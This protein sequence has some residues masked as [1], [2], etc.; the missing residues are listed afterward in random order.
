M[1]AWL[2]DELTGLKGLRLADVPAP[3]P[4]AGG[5]QE[6]ILFELLLKFGFPLT[7]QIEALTL[8]G[9]TVFSIADGTMLVCL[10]KEL[11]E[12]VIKEMAVRKPERFVCLD[13][14]FAGNDQL[15]TNAAQDMK[16]EGVTSF[17]IV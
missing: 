14:G 17:G 2:L 13:Q 4:V 15:K 5:T 6:D 16:A 11:A 3:L 9:K 7:T 10:E 8:A 12:G 1:Q